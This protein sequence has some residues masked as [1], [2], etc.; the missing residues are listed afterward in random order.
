[1]RVPRITLADDAKTLTARDGPF[2]EE[3]HS[4]AARNLSALAITETELKLNGSGGD[5]RVAVV[6]GVGKGSSLADKCTGNRFLPL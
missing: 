1:M 6:T 4:F 3:P 2:G 5:H